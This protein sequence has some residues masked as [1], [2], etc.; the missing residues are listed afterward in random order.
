MPT[1]APDGWPG[2]PR[3]TVHRSQLPLRGRALARGPDGHHR[4]IGVRYATFSYDAAGRAISTQPRRRRAEPYR[5]LRHR[6]TIAPSVP[7]W[8]APRWTRPS[9][10]RPRHMTDPL[11]TPQTYT[12]QGGDGQVRLLGAN[13]PFE[14]LQVANRESATP[15][16]CRCSESRLPGRAHN[17]TV[18]T[19]RASSR[20]ST[21]K[22]AGRPEAQT[23][24]HAVARKLPL[25]RPHHRS[26][27]HHRLHLRQPGQQGQRDRYRHGHRPGPY[28]AWT[29][30]RPGPGRN[31]D[32]PEGRRLEIRLRQRRQ[33][34]DRQEPTGPADQ[35]QL[36]RGRPRAPARPTRMAWSPPTPT[37]RAAASSRKTAAAKS[38][39][40]PTPP[41]GSWPV[42]RCPMACR[43]TT[44]TTP[45]SASS[46]PPTTAAT[47]SQYTLDAMGNRVREEV[48]RRQRQHRPGYRPHHQQP[49]QG[50]GHSGLVGQTTALAYD[51]NGEPVSADRP[52]EPDHPPER[53][54]ACAARPPP[55]SPTTPRP[56]RPGTSWTSSPRS[57]IPRACQTRYQT[58][59]FGEVMSETSPDI[60]TIAYTRDA[61]GE[62][63]AIQDAKGQI[64][65]IERDALGRPS[66]DRVRA[67]TTSPASAMTRPATSAASR[68]NPAAR[69]TP[70]TRR[71]GSLA[72]TQSVNDNPSSPTRSYKI[73]Y[74]YEGGRTRQ[75]RPTPAA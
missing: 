49:E 36:R 18:T 69:A 55:P 11:G 54:T 37:T 68:T 71:A 73:T 6:A 5:Q 65:R 40:S 20:L 16:T 61:N 10:D 4:R 38:L 7:W 62:V 46:P 31:H 42:P 66:A 59:A 32:R 52:A 2:S 22:A 17:S 50:G 15:S 26:R 1:T 47:A 67:R 23:D 58:N 57:P 72:K 39:P 75:R 60:G 34:H 27:P 25:A 48:Q 56:G 21:T 3:P 43:S 8:R 29:Y 28:L 74:T 14:G 44:A 33:S 19:L 63:I 45:P 53:W 30:N 41:T 51:A 13:G 24:Q 35:L 12:W 9:T 64:S 70:A